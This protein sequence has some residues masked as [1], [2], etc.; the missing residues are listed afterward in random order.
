MHIIVNW[1][2]PKEGW[3]GEKRRWI[4]EIREETVKQSVEVEQYTELG[5]KKMKIPKHL[6][7]VK[8][9]LNH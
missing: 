2:D 3:D 4:K 8:S 7:E 1:T 9:K 6:H 5:Y